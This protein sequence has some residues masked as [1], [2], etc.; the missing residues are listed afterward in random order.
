MTPNSSRRLQ[1]SHGVD[2]AILRK[3]RLVSIL[4]QLLI[5]RLY[6]AGTG[7]PVAGPRRQQPGLP[8]P[9]LH[10]VHLFR[11]CGSWYTIFG[12]PCN[13]RAAQ[14]PNSR[15][16][17]RSARPPGLGLRIT[18]AGVRRRW[19]QHLTPR[20]ALSHQR[21][22]GASGQLVQYLCADV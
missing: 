8:D 1:A 2:A 3:P 10:H 17:R 9:L 18:V 5:R 4:Y 15:T 20:A 14:A 19:R 7:P 11:A 6:R 12:S 16:G 21:V 13:S 22:S